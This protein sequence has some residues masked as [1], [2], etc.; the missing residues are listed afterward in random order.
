[1]ANNER[2]VTTIELNS[3]QAQD[4]LKKLI[5]TVEDLKRKK[6]EALSKGQSFLEEA[7]LKKATK[8]LKQWR[9]QMQGV[10]G[11]LNNIND[12]IAFLASNATSGVSLAELPT[13]TVRMAIA[14]VGILPILIL[15]PFFQK[16]FA[17]GITMGAV[18][19]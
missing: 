9:V 14:V 4:R 5:N 3:E 13:T 15:Y 12:N 18:K 19:G 10:Q 2:Y 1:M 17:K 11:V 6:N 7:E 16:Y 8:E